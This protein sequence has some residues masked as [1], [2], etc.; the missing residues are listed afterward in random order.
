MDKGS[1][2]ASDRFGL[3]LPGTATEQER[4]EVIATLCQEGYANRIALSHDTVMYSDWGPPGQ[5]AKVYPDWV[6]THVSDVILPALRAQG[7]SEEDIRTMMETTP[8]AL[9]T[10]IA[11]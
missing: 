2:V 9:F 11:R 4:V 7:V 3:S 5:A 8:A 6:P 1:V 10:G